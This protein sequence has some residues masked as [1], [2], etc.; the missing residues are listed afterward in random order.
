MGIQPINNIV[1]VT[2]EQRRDSPIL[3]H[4]SILPQTL[5]VIILYITLYLVF[6]FFQLT[7]YFPFSIFVSI[8]KEPSMQYKKKYNQNIHTGN[9]KEGSLKKKKSS[10]SL[11]SGIISVNIL[12]TPFQT[13]FYVYYMPDTKWGNTHTH[14]Y[15]HWG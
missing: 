7:N 3:I 6:C 2:G 8:M 4:V 15:T 1:I 5:G 10:I 12:D 13:I 14:I 9:I 11:P